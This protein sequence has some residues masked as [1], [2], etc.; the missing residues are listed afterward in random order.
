MLKPTTILIQDFMVKHLREMIID[1]TS[2]YVGEW[3]SS[4]SLCDPDFKPSDLNGKLPRFHMR[5][6]IAG[7]VKNDRLDT[8]EPFHV[9]FMRF[10]VNEADP[11][12][13]CHMIGKVFWNVN[14]RQELVSIRFR[15]NLFSANKTNAYIT[16]L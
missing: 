14:M 6:V 13:S 8:V 12:I 15:F 3:R 2:K 5:P 7:E 4:E 16:Y 1:E 10:N 9:E 11:Q